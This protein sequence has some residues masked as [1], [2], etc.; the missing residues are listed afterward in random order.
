[1]S[2]TDLVISRAGFPPFSARGVT[3]TLE[4]LLCGE[5]RRTIDGRLVYTGLSNH[6]K[7]K[8]LILCED[9]A[10]LAMGSLWRGAEVKVSCIASLTQECQGQ[11]GDTVVLMRP[12]VLGSIRLYDES[13]QRYEV[14]LEENG[15]VVTFTGSGDYPDKLYLTYRPLL[16]MR[17]LTFKI[18]TDEWGGKGGWRMTLEE[19]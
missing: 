5:M 4:P 17:I 10:A 9:K 11:K 19:I 12:A 7:Y 2:Q 14:R 15:T 1:M 13:H 6:Q 16:K 8:S 18:L 3:Q